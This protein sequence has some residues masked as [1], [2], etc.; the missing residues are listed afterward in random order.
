MPC[1][2]GRTQHSSEFD[3]NRDHIT[4]RFYTFF[5]FDF[6]FLMHKLIF[7]NSPCQPHI[8]FS[9]LFPRSLISLHRFRGNHVAI[10]LRVE[11]DHSSWNERFHL[12]LVSTQLSSLDLSTL[13][14]LTL[15]C[16]LATEALATSFRLT[17]HFLLPQY[18][19]SSHFF[20]IF[21]P[22]F[23]FLA[24]IKPAHFFTGANKIESKL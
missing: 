10:E 23:S 3:N 14:P 13:T 12:A 2:H 22:F 20:L 5:C 15:L 24:F 8:Y 7:L 1:W 16:Y 19:F 4:V 11:E 18:C 6:L 21:Q 17:A 9:P